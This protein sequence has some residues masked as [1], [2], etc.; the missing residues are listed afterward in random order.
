MQRSESEDERKDKQQSWPEVDEPAEVEQW[1]TRYSLWS[2]LVATTLVALSIVLL[3]YFSIFAVLGIFF[4]I[5]VT[6]YSLAAYKHPAR[7]AIVRGLWGI[8]LPAL[9]VIYDPG[10][11][12]ETW[13][14]PGS[15][16]M[17]FRLEPRGMLLIPP[18]ALQ[19]FGMGLWLLLAQRLPPSPFIEGFFYFGATLA[20]IIGLCLLPISLIGIILLGLGLLGLTPFLT[21]YH[22]VKTAADAGRGIGNDPS[23]ESKSS[24]WPVWMGLGYLSAI[25]L[26]LLC[27]QALGLLEGF[28]IAEMLRAVWTGLNSF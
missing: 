13:Y 2:L 12:H 8:V 23:D 6:D 19:S 17:R 22:F 24:L 3:K 4:V 5:I 21:A 27:S 28:T 25:G 9:C 16:D 11:L 14:F 20:S 10:F 26:S 18:I 7:P 15:Q 1:Q